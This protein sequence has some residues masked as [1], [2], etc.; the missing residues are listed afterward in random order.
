[1]LRAKIDDGEAADSGRQ[2]ETR[3]ELRKAEDHMY[4]LYSDLRLIAPL[5]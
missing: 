4:L 1:M 2:E 3:R 5:P